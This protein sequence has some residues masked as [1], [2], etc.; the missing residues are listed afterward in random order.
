MFR[1]IG[2]LNSGIYFQSNALRNI[3]NKWINDSSDEV[4]RHSY[5]AFVGGSMGDCIIVV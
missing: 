5:P 4:D 2:V 3:I 1:D